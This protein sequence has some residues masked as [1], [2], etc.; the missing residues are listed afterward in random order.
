M[1]QGIVIIGLQPQGLALLQSLGP[2]HKDLHVLIDGRLNRCF[3]EYSRYGR[4]YH[5][6]SLQSLAVI[7]EDIQRQYSDKL[8]C[9]ITSAY[10]LTEIRTDYRELYD[11][12]NVFSSPLK[13]VDL[14]S[15]KH[16]MYDFVRSFGVKTM[17]YIPL[18]EYKHGVLKFPLILKR[19]VEFFLSFKTKLVES[20]AEFD[21]F[22][23]SIP[24]NPNHIIVQEMITGNDQSD[25]AFHAYVHRGK[26]MGSFVVEEV[27]HYPAG[28]STFLRECDDEIS[29]QITETSR[30]FIEQTEYTG[31]IQIDY[32]Y[33][34]DSR[35]PLI[36]DINTRTPASHSAFRTKFVNSTEFYTDI[37]NPVRLIP[38]K[39]RL[40]W[41]SI[42]GDIRARIHTRDFSNIGSM[43]SSTWDVFDKRDILPF[44]LWFIIPTYYR[45]KSFIISHLC[46]V[47]KNISR[48]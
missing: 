34:S 39:N 20:E 32:K 5:F 12:Y 45:I 17:N 35:T 1:N 47:Q 11:R 33:L 43:F 37:L 7:L 22:V 44:L 8:N 23:S 25:L 21:A 6:D 10:L 2:Y 3:E 19:N 24:D 46:S 40:T 41:I 26:V 15:T 18:T 30:Q 13:W 38:K 42:V 16:L 31:F 48:K 14:F 36:M 29:V 28:I 9:F 4:K 27:R